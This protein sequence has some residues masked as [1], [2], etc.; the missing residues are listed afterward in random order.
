LYVISL[1][2][3]SIVMVVTPLFG[4]R[5]HEQILFGFHCLAFGWILFPAWLANPFLLGAAIAYGL[6]RHWIA[7]WLTGI[8]I[9]LG[10]MTFLFLGSDLRYP[11]V[12][13]FVWIA[14]MVVF[15]VAS[16]RRQ[17]DTE[18]RSGRA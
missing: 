7:A 9:V 2:L 1:I 13:F 8:A 3:P 14:S 4:G 17:R 18:V 6:K 16:V 10:L 11:H 5:E 12:G 15:F